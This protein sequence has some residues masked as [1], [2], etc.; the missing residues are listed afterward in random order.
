MRILIS[1]DDGVM[2]EG[3][4]VLAYELAKIATIIVMAPDR[5]RSGASNSL[6]LFEPIRIKQLENGFYSVQGTPTD[7]VHLGLTGFLDPLVDLVVSGINDGANLGDDVFYSGT[8][9]AAMEG[10]HCGF[11]AI[12]VSTVGKSIKHYQTAA[13]ITRQFIERLQ[14]Q[15][16][17]KK[18]FIISMFQ[19]SLFLK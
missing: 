10:R 5:N 17:P 16:L 11:P 6:T 13:T 12:A 7:C 3:L 8:V 1:N 18:L 2:A 14:H 9:A 19:T 15:M 4:A